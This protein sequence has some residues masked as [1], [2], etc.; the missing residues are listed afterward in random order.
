MT[1]SAKEIA[2]LIYDNKIVA[3]YSGR[4]E[5]GPRALWKQINNLRPNRPDCK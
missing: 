3:F 2:K 5:Y 1:D 4:M